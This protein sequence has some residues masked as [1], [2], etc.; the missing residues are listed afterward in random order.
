[1][2]SFILGLILAIFS[3][4]P[5]QVH[6]RGE[7]SDALPPMIDRAYAMG[8]RA[9]FIFDLDETTV[10]STPRRYEAM[11]DALEEI[12]RFKPRPEDCLAVTQSPLKIEDMYHQRNR[13]DDR[14]WIRNAGAR[15]DAFIEALAT[16]MFSIYLSGKYIVEKDRLIPGAKRFLLELKRAGAQVYFV[17]SRSE[18]SQRRP[19]LEF[20]RI[21]GLLRPGEERMLYVRPDGEGTPDFKRRAAEQIQR[22]VGAT[23]GKV[24][25]IFENEPEN[26]TIWSEIFPRAKAFFITGAYQREAPVLPKAVILDDY[27]Y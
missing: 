23:G 9:A 3:L 14:A 24:V 10:D 25:G 2:H 7:P 8:P 13:Y 16:R 22:R 15:N 12:C 17:S 4:M 27:R 19:T 18:E 21:R 5:A 1:M 26:L 20:L 6:A 11:L